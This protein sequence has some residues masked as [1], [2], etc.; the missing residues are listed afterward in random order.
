MIKAMTE[1]HKAEM[2]LMGA[3]IALL[4][5]G[6][7]PP[8]GVPKV[9]GPVGP[10]PPVFS[11]KK[12][13]W[14]C[15]FPNL[16]NYGGDLVRPLSQNFLFPIF[17]VAPSLNAISMIA[18]SAKPWDDFLRLPRWNWLIRQHLNIRNSLCDVL[19]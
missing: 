7:V 11:L 17:D 19:M 8:A 10:F 13:W 6:G 4:K 16:E 5:S 15:L 14:E 3:Q 18:K 2:D 9:G 1:S 12:F